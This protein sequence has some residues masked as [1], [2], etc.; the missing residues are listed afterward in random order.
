MNDLDVLASEY[1]NSGS[2]FQISAKDRQKRCDKIFALRKQA[3]GVQ[4][5]YEGYINNKGAMQVDEEQPMIRN[6]GQDGEYD[7][8]RDLTSEQIL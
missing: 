7:Q 5:Q 2:K 8:T 1:Q 6:K 3:N 4:G